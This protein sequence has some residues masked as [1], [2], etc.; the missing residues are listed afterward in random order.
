MPNESNS[1]VQTRLSLQR[2]RF[3]WKKVKQKYPW[4]N[5]QKWEGSIK[6][7]TLFNGL[8]EEFPRWNNGYGL[9]RKWKWRK[10]MHKAERENFFQYY[11]KLLR[12]T[13]EG[14]SLT[15]VQ[16]RVT[17]KHL[18]PAGAR[19]VTWIFV[20][21]KICRVGVAIWRTLRYNY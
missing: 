17:V 12:N 5:M 4:F 11:F 20:S 2:N 6:N 8:V 18:A 1:T 9:R 16:R 3:R 21:N 19:Y 13:N 14:Y 7:R 15:H 10:K